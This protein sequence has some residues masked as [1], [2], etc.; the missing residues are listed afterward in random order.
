MRTA[1]TLLVQEWFRPRR[2]PQVPTPAQLHLNQAESDCR[3]AM[4]A[5]YRRHLSDDDLRGSIRTLHEAEW[6]V[7]SR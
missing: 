3:S 6:A 7:M 5:W 1:V 2:R 4:E